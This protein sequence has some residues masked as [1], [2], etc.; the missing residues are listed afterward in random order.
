MGYA[1]DPLGPC[2][3][4]G[5]LGP[6]GVCWESSLDPVGVLG[7]LLGPVA[8]WGVLGV[9]LGPVASGGCWRLHR[10]GAPHCLQGS[11][12]PPVFLP[13]YKQQ[14]VG[15]GLGNEANIYIHTW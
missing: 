14:G 4:V 2:G 5:P 1:G 6:C 7:V 11:R 12:G 15:R 9:L 3:L 8:L 13:Y 10:P